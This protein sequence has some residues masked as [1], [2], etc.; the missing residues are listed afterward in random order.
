MKDIELKSIHTLRLLAADAVQKANS[1]HPGMPMGTAAMVV[2]LFRRVMRHNPA[3]PSWKNRDRFV[4]SGG[5]GSAVLYGIL[6]LTGYDIPLDEIK[7]F[8]QL[9]SLTPGHPEYRHTPGVETTTGPLGQGMANA[10]GFAIAEARLAAEFNTPEANIVDHYTYCICGDGDMMEGVS[11]EA[12][13]LAG[14]LKLGKLVVLYDDNEISIEGDTDIS[15]RENVPARFRAYGWHVIELTDGNDA[16]AIENAI[17]EA[18]ADD[19]PSLIVCPTIIG[20]GSPKAGKASAHGEPLGVDALKATKREFG[21]DPEQS[22]V[23]PDD[24]REYMNMREKGAEW[25]VEWEKICRQTPEKS[26][27][28][29][30][31]NDRKLPAGVDDESL[32]AFEGKMATRN[33]SGVAL[34]RLAERLPNL[35]GGSADLAPSNKSDMKKRSDFSAENRAGSNMHFGVREH[36]M[37][38]ICNAIALHGGLRPYCATFFVFSDY[39]R[40]AM[41]LS[42]L[43]KL[44]LP[45]I[46]THDSI[47]VGEDGPTHQPVEHLDSLRAVP[48]MLVF[49]PADSREVVAG[50]LTALTENRPTCLVLT[51]QD[52]PLYPNSGREAMKGGYIISDSIKDIP[53]AIL[54]ASGSEVEQMIEAQLILRGKNVD[55]RVVS[56]PCMEIFDEQPLQ[57]RESVLPNAVRARVAM[58]AAIGQSWWKYVGLDGTIIRMEGFGASGP[59]KKLF[60]KYGFTADNVVN[61]TSQVL[62]KLNNN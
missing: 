16:D 51:R 19:R 4:L 28:L 36:A 60:A 5:H 59:A 43:M 10:V 57:Y 31:W 54:L 3:D 7:Q 30:A 44:S 50:W 2:T 42:A 35:F 25:Q 41:R 22:F 33:S 24:V 46:L 8:R 39:M 45:Y 20:Y 13:S 15:F 21:F 14:T 53:D 58:E 56:I 11:S 37:A 52:L 55:A 1:G 6:H 9:D 61:K 23:V 38:A 27:G 26:A 48:G 47:G 18:K 12:A 40:G 17:R 62:D 29:D 32:W 49:R 34:N